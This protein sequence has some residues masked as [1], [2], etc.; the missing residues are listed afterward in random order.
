VTR[1]VARA[2]TPGGSVTGTTAAAEA[3]P[4]AWAASV[5]G[6]TAT[7]EATPVAGAIPTA[8]LDPV[9]IAWERLGRLPDP[10]LPVVS[11]VELGMVHRIDLEDGR[12]RVT[13]LPTYLGC[14]ALELIRAAVGRFLADLAGEVEVGVALDPP[15]TTERI[16]EAGRVK[17]KAA[18]IAPPPRR[19]VRGRE[20]GSQPARGSPAL[21][22]APPLAPLPLASLRPPRCP[23]CGSRRTVLEGA[24]G[25]TPCRAIAY[26]TGCRQP[27]EVV[28]PL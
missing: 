7:A 4:V 11:V 27:F 21:Q 25:P 9:A 28:K 6:A 19:R 12:L 16:S 17:L 10:E 15:W 20:D 3:I 26:C 23:H 24:F 1:Q 13:L 8:A 5:A 14:P 22:A 2:A 18:G